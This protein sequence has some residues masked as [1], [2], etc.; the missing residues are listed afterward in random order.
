MNPMAWPKTLAPLVLSAALVAGCNP[1]DG[2]PPAPSTT[3]K[4]GIVL[5]GD[6][7]IGVIWVK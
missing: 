4:T 2:P 7:R 6:A 1:F 5:S 3:A